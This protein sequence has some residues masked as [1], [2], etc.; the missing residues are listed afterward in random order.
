MG[1]ARDIISHFMS[2]PRFKESLPLKSDLSKPVIAFANDTG[3]E[4][5][6]GIK[7]KPREVIGL[8]EDELFQKEEKAAS[9]IHYLCTPSILPEISFLHYEG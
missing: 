1:F 3:G 2:S 6:V 4:I 8:N 7:D 5:Y 9:L